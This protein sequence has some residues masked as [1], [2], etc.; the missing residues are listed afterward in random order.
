MKTTVY[1]ARREIVKQCP[2]VFTAREFRALAGLSLDAAWQTCRRLVELGALRMEG[3]GIYRRPD[4]EIA[5]PVPFHLA[6]ALGGEGYFTGRGVLA[7]HP[8][9]WAA[10]AIGL[11]L[12]SGRRLG[13][14]RGGDPVPVRRHRLEL[15]KFPYGLQPWDDGR[16]R[17][18]V[19]TPERVILDSL[20]C[21]GRFL[22]VAEIMTLLGRRHRRVRPLALIDLV[23]RFRSETVRRRLRVLS[24][25]AGLR[26]LPR[27]LAQEGPYSPRMGLVWLDPSLADRTVYAVSHGVRVNLD[28]NR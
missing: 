23:A 27:W 3:R 13:P 1:Q 12:V 11:D 4:L 8:R 17:F 2:A 15:G 21:P 26:R 28:P 7:P 22:S 18:A 9:R 14:V 19:A 6:L 20:A 25:L 24:E 16:R 10:A 5:L